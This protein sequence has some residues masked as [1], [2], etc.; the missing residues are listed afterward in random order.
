MADSYD[1]AIVGGGINGAGVAQAAAAAGHRVL[2]LEQSALAHGTSSRSSKLI[3]GGLRYLET[4]QV[5]LVRESL[6]ERTVLLRLAPEL[7][8]LVPFHIPIYRSTRRR[9]WQVR[10]GLA[11]YALLGGCRTENRF[12]SLPRKEWDRLDG[13]DTCELQAVFRYYDGQ[14]DDAALTRAVARSAQSLGA[15]LVLPGR[16]EGAA[17]EA[18]GCSVDFLDGD[19][20]RTCRARVLVNAAGPWV[21]RVAE[22]ITPAPPRQDI[23]LV[24][25]THIVVRGG[26]E[27]GIYYLESPGDGRA[28]FAMPR[29]GQTLVGTTEAIYDGDPQLVS[30]P[31]S[32][33][34]YL[35]GILKHY[36]PGWR[37]TPPDVISAYAGLRVLPR[38]AGRAFDRP[39]ETIYAADRLDRPRVLSIYGG[40]LTTFRTTAQKV[41]QRIAPSLPSRNPVSGTDQLRLSPG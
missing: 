18:E 2:L 29:S 32:E 21:N 28:V 24:R 26:L 23:D 11:L 14:T 13:I 1:V 17:L 35:C 3:H 30:P 12:S 34:E 7:V 31:D 25:G 27:H 22:R 6:H 37:A 19:R 33:R 41:M 10:A 38:G 15:E 16:F 39:R 20:T 36:F 4:A 5:A 8:R 40:K 9:P